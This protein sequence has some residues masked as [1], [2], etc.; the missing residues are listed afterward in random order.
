METSNPWVALLQIG[1]VF[2]LIIGLPVLM[3]L[4]ALNHPTKVP[5]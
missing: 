1:G 5:K 3:S 4:W 2:F